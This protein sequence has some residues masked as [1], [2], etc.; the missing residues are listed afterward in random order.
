MLEDE[1]CCFAPHVF[2]FYSCDTTLG[3]SVNIVTCRRTQVECN[4]GQLQKY[5]L[6]NY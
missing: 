5:L 2:L 1:T 3:T 4:G 6:Y